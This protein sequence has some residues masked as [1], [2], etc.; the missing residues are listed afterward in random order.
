MKQLNATAEKKELR[1]YRKELEDL[2]NQLSDFLI[3]KL[4]TTRVLNIG[5]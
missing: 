1:E 5:E 4:K 2:I 3:E